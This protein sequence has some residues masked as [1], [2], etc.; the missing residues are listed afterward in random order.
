MA[1]D[2]KLVQGEVI[3]DP[4]AS[5]S[6]EAAVKRLLEGLLRSLLAESQGSA[7]AHPGQKHE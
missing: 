6:D 4:N 1:A 7:G 2:G 3:E 5:K